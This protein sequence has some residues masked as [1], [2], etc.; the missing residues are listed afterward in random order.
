[1][2]EAEWYYN[3]VNW[4]FES[5]IVKGMDESTFAPNANITR[6][7]MAIMLENFAVYAGISLPQVNSSISFT[8]SSVIS[9]WAQ[10]SVNKIVSSAIM[11]G[12]P[13]GN[14]DPKG[15]ATRAQ[16]AT[17]VYKYTIIRDNIAA[18]GK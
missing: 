10:D 6:E 1:M 3:Y 12:H 14:F 16:A 9:P 8:D 5:G 11:G 15:N 2:P 18:L 13:E 4:G 17:V 7:Q